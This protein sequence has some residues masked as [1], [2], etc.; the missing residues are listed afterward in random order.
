VA[1][2]SPRSLCATSSVIAAVI[3]VP[4]GAVIIHQCKFDKP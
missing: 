3:T 2:S 1:I 4:F